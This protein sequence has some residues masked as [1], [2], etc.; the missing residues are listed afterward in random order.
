M[1]A[2]LPIATALAVLT[3]CAGAPPAPPAPVTEAPAARPTPAAVAPVVTRLEGVLAR[4]GRF[5][6][7]APTADDTLASIA[8]R[9][10]GDR[11]RGWEIADFNGVTRLEPGKVVA[12][13]L[14]P[15]NPK[16]VTPNGYQMVPILCYHRFGPRPSRMVITPENFERQLEYLAKN[17]YRVVRLADLPDFLEGRRPLPRR[18]VVITVDDGHVSAWQHAWPLLKKYGFP[19][20]FYMYTDFMGAKEGLTTA[21]LKEMA[22]SGLIDFQS[23][24]K[25]HANLTQRLPNESD[26]R[27][28][29]RIEQE[30]RVPRDVLQRS[31]GN[32]VVHYAYPYGDANEIVL[33]RMREAQF[34]TG[35]TVNPGGNAFYAHPLMLR[36]TMVFG[37]H[38]LDQFRAMLQVFREQNLQ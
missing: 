22:A 15:V 29:E 31:L 37:E 27:Y 21:Q 36:R 32:R 19:A 18:A 3:G 8:E 14:E 11:A 7:Y 30:I 2:I 17:D 6:I 4:N 38:D 12:I 33:E 13:A 35:A 26:Q 5:V 1:R 10:L 9:F 16:G 24:S 23:H 34:R 25:T 28:R 20:T